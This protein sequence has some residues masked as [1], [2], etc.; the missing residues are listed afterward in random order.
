MRKYAVR[1]SADF[2]VFDPKGPYVVKKSIEARSMDAAMNT[3]ERLWDDQIEWPDDPD[4][5]GFVM[6]LEVRE[7]GRKGKWKTVFDRYETLRENYY[8]S[9]GLKA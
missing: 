8:R 9:M 4:I 5:L 3:A 7:S 2:P 6:R 1:I